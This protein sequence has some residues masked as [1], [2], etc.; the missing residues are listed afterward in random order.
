M[1]KHASYTVRYNGIGYASKYTLWH[2]RK[3][4]RGFTMDSILTRIGVLKNENCK[5]SRQADKL[6]K[7]LVCIRGQAPKSTDIAGVTAKCKILRVKIT[8]NFGKIDALYNL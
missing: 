7:T 8:E 4:E 6:A 3:K 5:L 1:F 2:R